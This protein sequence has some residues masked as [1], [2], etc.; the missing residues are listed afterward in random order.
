MEVVAATSRCPLMA[1]LAFLFLINLC[2]DLVL[3]H[4]SLQ[5]MQLYLLNFSD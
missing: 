1:M 2:F 5:L 4:P 3:V